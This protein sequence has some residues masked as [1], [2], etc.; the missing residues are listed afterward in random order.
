MLGLNEIIE[1]EQTC[2]IKEHV[3]RDNQDQRDDYITAFINSENYCIHFHLYELREPMEW[4][5][6]GIK[7]FG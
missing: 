2:A 3:M 5:E 7:A 6:E 4:N 1:K